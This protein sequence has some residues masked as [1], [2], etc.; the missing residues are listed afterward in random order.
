MKTDS[1][2][3]LEPFRNRRYFGVAIDPIHIGAGGYRIGRVDNTIV[4][5]AGTNIPKIPGSSLAGVGRAYSAM[6]AQAKDQGDKYLSSDKKSCAGSGGP[7]GEN[8]CGKSDCP[9]CMAYGFSKKSASGKNESFQGLAQFGDAHPWLFPFNTVAGNVWITSPFRL[10]DATGL[11]VAEPG[12]EEVRVSARLYRELMGNAGA[13]M[14]NLGWVTYRA[15]DAGD[16]L[17]NIL[18][19]VGGLSDALRRFMTGRIVVVPDE[20]YSNLVNLGLEVRTSVSIDPATGAAANG[21]LF[22]Y[23]AIPRTT[24]F[25]FD[26]TV[27][28]PKFVKPPSGPC[29]P[30]ISVESVFTTVQNGFKYMPWLGVGGMTTRGMGRFR[31]WSAPEFPV[32]EGDSK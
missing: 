31:A 24:V 18:S 14:I 20:Q 17:N 8:H 12:T 1:T 10:M 23:E 2:Q 19:K 16:K 15:A 26:M 13:R 30:T 25:Y 27:L 3:I 29:A 9:I 21:A 32:E 28:E 11:E 22:T 4:R 5:D 7:G 6:Y